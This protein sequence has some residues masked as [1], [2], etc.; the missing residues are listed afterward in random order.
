MPGAET[1]GQ[2]VFYVTEPES[3][4]GLATEGP[5][6]LVCESARA[7]LLRD[8][9]PPKIIPFRGSPL[10]GTVSVSGGLVW[11]AESVLLSGH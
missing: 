11:G 5:E 8:E 7:G 4:Q 6:S 10:P 1:R 3:S 2:S 9:H